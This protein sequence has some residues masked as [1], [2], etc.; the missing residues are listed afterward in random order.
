MRAATGLLL[1]ACARTALDAGELDANG[2][3]PGL[4]APSL[5]TGGS[6]APAA[7]GG[8]TGGSAPVLSSGGRA[9]AQCLPT[10]ETCNG[11]DDDC[12]GAVDDL[13]ALPCPTGGFSYCIGGV[14]SACPSR[15][16]TCIPGSERACFVSFCTFW[17]VQTCTADG[18]S[19]G[20]CRE[21]R[22]PSECAGVAGEG[23]NVAALEQCCIDN[24]YCCLDNADLDHDG[25]MAESLG[26]CRDVSC[27][28]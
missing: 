22:V 27:N 6:L 4:P 8:A 11:R 13:P 14:Q 1:F 9:Q 21:Q 17:G 20:S 19:F 12:N 16:E 23:P 26:N 7:S 3:G 18:R 15:C 10:P 2:A 24:G 25:N 5:G 28:P